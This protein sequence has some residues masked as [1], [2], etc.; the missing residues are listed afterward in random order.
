MRVGTEQCFISFYPLDQ[1]R[2][3]MEQQGRTNERTDGGDEK[4]ERGWERA[5]GA[6]C[7][8]RGRVCG[9][10]CCWEGGRGFRVP[11]LTAISRGGSRRDDNTSRSRWRI[12]WWREG[13]ANVGLLH[14]V[15]GLAVTS[16]TPLGACCLPCGGSIQHRRPPVDRI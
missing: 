10:C 16:P 2:N 5:F 9:W 7:R 6:A 3:S 8:P 1:N 14:A 4:E 12:R 11:P 15:A 13:K